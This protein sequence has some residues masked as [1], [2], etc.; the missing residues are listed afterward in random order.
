MEHTT[1][2]EWLHLLLYN[3]LE[4][5]E[6]Q[7]LETHLASC[8]ECREELE[9]LKRFHS[10]LAEHPLAESAVETERMLGDARRRLRGTL[11]DARDRR[12]PAERVKEFVAGIFSPRPAFAFAAI[13]I[14]IIGVALGRYV[15]APQSAAVGQGES[16]GQTSA[17]APGDSHI[18][19]VRFLGNDPAA[20]EI[21]FTFDA[22]TPVHIKGNVNDAQVQKVLT[23]ALLDEEN[24]GVRLQSVNAIASQTVRIGETDKQVQNALIKA[25]KSDQNPGVRKEALR[26][27]LRY[28]V[29]E[30]IKAA[31]LYSLVHDK[32]AGIRIAVINS[33]DSTRTVGKP[34]D[35]DVLEVL[36]DRMSTDDNNYIRVRA[37][38]AVLEGHQ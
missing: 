1:Y 3:E 20:G 2:K 5:G 30:S 36:K 4:E 35:K 22:V 32:N 14:L 33:L 7:S 8:A 12:S 18:S 11:A 29:D 25:L 28:P 24:P 17:F 10:L 16:L 34:L 27:L 38:A 21:E 31:F 13:A 19:N 6:K 23:H 15:L 26:A 9:G 37:K